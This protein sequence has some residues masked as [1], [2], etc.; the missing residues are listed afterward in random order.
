MKKCKIV[1]KLPKSKKPVRI[2]KRTRLDGV[3]TF[4]IQQKHFL[5]WWWWVDAWINNMC[6]ADC[7]DTFYTLGTAKYNLR[8]FN[9]SE[10]DEC[11]VAQ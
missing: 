6:G 5:F 4:V 9:G 2:I 8:Y 10:C 7:I 3:E 1:Y 11:I